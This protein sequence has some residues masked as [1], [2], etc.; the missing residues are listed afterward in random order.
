MSA[1][2]TQQR[3]ALPAALLLLGILLIG[4]NLRAPFTGLPPL[5]AS[6]QADFALETMAVGA[7][8]TL[9]LLAFAL[10]SPFSALI[11]RQYGL[12]RTLF[13]ALVAIAL[14]IAVRSTGALWSLYAGTVI[15]GMGIAVGNVLLPSLVKRDFP[16]RV[17]ALTSAYVLSM[18]V[19]AALGSAAVVPVAQ[20][21]G[22]SGALAAF[23]VLPLA[24]L[25][26]WIAQLGAKTKPASVSTTPP[27]ASKVWR[28]ALAWQITLFLGLNSTI[29]YVAIAWLPAILIDAGFSAERA[30]SMHGVLQLA[31]AVPGLL[32]GPILLRL[33]DQRLPAAIVAGLSVIALVGLQALPQFAVA[34][35]ILFGLGTGAGFILG[36]S[37]IGLRT[38]N[39][40]QAAALSGMAQC[41]GYLLAAT[42]PMAMGALHDALGGWQIPLGLCAALALVG[43][44]MGLLAGRDRQIGPQGQP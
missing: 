27:H 2:S 1:T 16:D 10:V 9:P 15:I 37:F 25:S 41:I 17:A 42:G 22:W 4:A 33:R 8:T 35:S 5:L 7:L 32:L 21:V 24:A 29:N 28:S 31:N 6:I 39:A 12:E 26:I 44:L 23:M 43:A 3:T 20:A 19:A 40:Q 11:A 30:G 36:L 18:S 34:W 38:R 14:G 13:G